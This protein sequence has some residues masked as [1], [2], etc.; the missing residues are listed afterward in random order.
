MTRFQTLFLVVEIA[1]ALIAAYEQNSSDDTLTILAAVFC[2]PFLSVIG[3]L[4]LWQLF[5]QPRTAHRKTV[6]VLVSLL[7]PLVA[8]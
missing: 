4:S 7:V 6:V 2:L 3:S 5:R 1:Y 8:Y